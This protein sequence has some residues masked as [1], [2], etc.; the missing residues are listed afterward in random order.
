[1]FRYPTG[2][3][4]SSGFFDSGSLVLTGQRPVARQVKG[5]PVEVKPLPKEGQPAWFR[6]AVGVYEISA[7]A[8]PEETSVGDPIT[9][10]LSITG[11]GRL[12]QLQP[13]PLPDLPELTHGFKV[14]TDP[15]AG[16][17]EGKIK[18][19]TQSIRA[20]SDSVK[21]IPSI[22]FAYFDPRQGKYVTVRS[23]PIPIKV[24]P[25][26][27][28]SSSQVVDATAKGPVARTLT[29]VTSGILANYTSEDDLLGQ[30]DVRPGFGLMALVILSPVLFCVCWVIQYHRNRCRRIR[31][32]PDGG[33]RG[34]RLAP[35]FMNEASKV[36][37]RRSWRRSAGT[38][39]TVAICH[40]AA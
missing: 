8:K 19:F 12:D 38:S 13:P 28:L 20:I 14:P 35:G 3:R 1:M 22:P 40:P 29:E 6:G 37:L 17:V 36:R 21:E 18:R 15:L 9:L 4:Q 16:E 32:S 33:R 10:T 30:Q 39:P 34:V 23:K 24:K 7:T 26:D 25:A 27:K 11:T 31:R 5:G 2:L